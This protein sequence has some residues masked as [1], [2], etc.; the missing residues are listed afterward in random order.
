MLNVIPRTGGNTFSGTAFVNGANASLQ[1]SN[2]TQELKDAGLT[3][4]NPLI[5]LYDV[6]GAIGGPL[7]KDRVWFFGTERIQGSSS[8]ISS[9]SYNKNAGLANA[10]T[11][12][13]DLNRQGFEDHTWENTTLRLTWQAAP[14]HKINIFWDEQID[15]SELR[16]RRVERERAVL[17]RSQRQR[18]LLPAAHAAGDVV[19]AR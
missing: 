11:Y 13:P 19:V 2:Y 18:G 6:S 1:G 3:S 4:P 8:Y 5:N 16:E 7:K 17:A 15:L 12:V 10:W 14:R 9:L